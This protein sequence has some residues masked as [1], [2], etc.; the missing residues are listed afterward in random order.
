[1][2]A[3]RGETWG[4]WRQVRV[5]PHLEDQVHSYH[6]VEEEVAVEQP[7]AGVVCPEPQHHVSVVGNGDGVLPWW[8][9]ELSVEKTLPV[10]VQCVLQVD[11]PNVGVW[12]S[13]Y[14]DH[15]E[16]VTVKMERVAQI[17]LLD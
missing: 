9:I 2:V 8:E 17:W 13:A 14:T 16:G 15:V 4:D 1:M 7:E 11:F 6:Y 10:Q 3:A 5:G 12:G